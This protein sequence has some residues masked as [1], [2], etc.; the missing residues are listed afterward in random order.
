MNQEEVESKVKNILMSVGSLKSEIELEDKLQEDIGM[1]SL[2][3][4]EI[5]MSLEDNYKITISDDD[6]EKI[7]T[8]GDVVDY[9]KEK[10]EELE[11]GEID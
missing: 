2:D 4:I 5:V 11:R 9:I 10:V 6:I 3:T 7:E 8:V 1:D